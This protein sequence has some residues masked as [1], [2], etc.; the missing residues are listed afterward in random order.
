MLCV[1]T[2]PGNIYSGHVSMYLFNPV[3]HRPEKEQTS[4][5]DHWEGD[6]FPG[7]GRRP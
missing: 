7:G 3:L 6:A 2:Y 5:W 4:H 1:T